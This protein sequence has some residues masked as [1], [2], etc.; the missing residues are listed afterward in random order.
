LHVTPV[1]PGTREAF[2]SYR[3]PSGPAESTLQIGEPTDTLNVFVRQPSHL[4]AISGLTT[5]RRVSAEG[6]EFLQYSGLGLQPGGAVTFSWS[7]GQGPPV[8]PVITAVVL[9]VLLL[10]IGTFAA[11]RNR[12][13]TL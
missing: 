5:T 10:A 13:Q 12:N 4:T 2:I 7:R 1:T 11:L 9:T 8:D 3:L 6:E